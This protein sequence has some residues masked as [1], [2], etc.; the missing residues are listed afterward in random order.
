MPQRGS[1]AGSPDSRT[2]TARIGL[3]VRV[4]KSIR[5]LPVVEVVRADAPSK[6]IAL[7]RH[8]ALVGWMND[9]EILIVENGVLAAIDVFKGNRRNS[10]VKVAD[11]SF[12]FLR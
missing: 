8:A 4:S 1:C 9:S 10:P 6:P 7:L 12:V 2:G 5:D 11:E 3:W